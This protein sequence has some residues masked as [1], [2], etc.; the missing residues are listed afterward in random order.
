LDSLPSGRA[1]NSSDE[2]PEPSCERLL[3]IGISELQPQMI[4]EVAMTTSF[5]I[6]DESLGLVDFL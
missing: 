4:A 1:S 5:Y 6:D 2:P 3:A